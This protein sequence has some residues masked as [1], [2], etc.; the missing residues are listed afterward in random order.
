VCVTRVP[1][2]VKHKPSEIAIE[3]SLGIRRFFNEL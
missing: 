1:F 2:E 3:S